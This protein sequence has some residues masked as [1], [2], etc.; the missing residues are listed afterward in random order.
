MRTYGFFCTIQNDINGCCVDTKEINMKM[1]GFC[2]PADLEMNEQRD[3]S[4][5]SAVSKRIHFE[6]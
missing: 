1:L 3:V 6:K 2:D 4:E 5:M